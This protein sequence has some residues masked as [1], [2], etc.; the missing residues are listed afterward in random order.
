[1][2]CIKGFVNFFLNIN[3]HNKH[4]SI[5]DYIELIR[6]HNAASIEILAKEG[7]LSIFVPCFNEACRVDKVDIIKDENEDDNK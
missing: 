5:E 3:E 4:V 7:Y 2:V 1:M 6:K